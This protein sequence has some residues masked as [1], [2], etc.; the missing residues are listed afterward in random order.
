MA[1]S[2]FHIVVLDGYTL[3]G[4]ELN[5]HGLERFGTYSCYD[6]TLPDQ[7]IERSREADAILVNKV[8]I[9]AKTIS[10]LPRLKYIGVTATGV[11]IVDVSAAK[12]RD[13]TVTNVPGYA[14]ASVAQ[15]VFAHLLNL[16]QRVEHHAHAVRDGRWTSSPD[17]CFWETPQIEISG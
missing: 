5:W 12:S 4:A 14:T 15:T 13:I 11:N 9:D 17:F 6:R 8:C 16:A 2:S 10:E 1:S 3:A 7:V